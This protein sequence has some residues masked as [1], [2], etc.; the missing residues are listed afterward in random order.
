[1][2]QIAGEMYSLIMNRPFAQT[3]DKTN[4]NQRLRPTIAR[5]GRAFER[6]SS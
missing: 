2:Y 5:I 1:M 6:I 3:K 4:A